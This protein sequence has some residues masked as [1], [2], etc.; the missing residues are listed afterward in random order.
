MNS[1]KK[2]PIPLPIIMLIGII[3]ISFS[4]IFIR[5]SDAPVS[6]IA[7]YRLFL[8]NLLMLPFIWKHLPTIRR[9]SLRSWLLLFCSGLMLGLHFLFWMGSLRFTTVA[10]S[11]AIMALEPIL[12]MLGSY[13][14]FAHKAS[15]QSILGVAIAIIGAVMIGWGDFGLSMRALQGDLLSLLG[16]IAVVFHMLLGSSLRSHMSAF[17]YSF[18]VFFMAGAVLAVYN[19][20]VGISF[21]G[22]SANDWTMF[23]LLAI[24]PTIL[25]H[26][27]F[28]WLLKYLKPT[29]V[30]MS[31]LGEPIGSTILAYYLLDESIT[32]MQG[33][34]G[35]L[36]LLGVWLFI[37]GEN[38]PVSTDNKS[39]PAAAEA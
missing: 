28:N 36:L 35:A 15:L 17:V 22:Y 14:L 27:L 18:F 31:V 20:F 26:Y 25:G 34:A 3:A 23:L 8:T 5:W 33:A 9:I 10:S 1:T 32:L 24:V 11:T 7:M 12:V 19:L 30:S 16:T 37:R 21:T 13:F 29:T 6:V 2:F 39:V 4:S 38:A